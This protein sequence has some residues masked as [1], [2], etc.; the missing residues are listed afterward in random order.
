MSDLRLSR[1]FLLSQ[2]IA[3]E[4]AASLG[5]DNTPR[6]DV[7]VSNLT[8]LA[9][10][11][12]QPLAEHFRSSLR[13]T[14]GYRCPALNAHV[15]GVPT[16]QHQKG[17]AADFIIDGHD[18]LQVAQWIADHMIFDQLILEEYEPN[19]GDGYLHCSYVSEY[20][21]NTAFPPAVFI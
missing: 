11:I 7:I 3:S 21:N 6:D 12:L 20:V 4:E 18:C 5:I 17:E 8:A 10:N 16:S 2:L 15:G 13:I 1:D 19:T 14:S 9:A